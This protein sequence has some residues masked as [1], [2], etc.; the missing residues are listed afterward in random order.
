[1]LTLLEQNSVCRLRG[2]GLSFSH[3]R[4]AGNVLHRLQRSRVDG[5]PKVFL[6]GRTELGPALCCHWIE[7][8]SLWHVV[9]KQ[10]PLQKS[11]VLRY[12]TKLRSILKKIHNCGV[13]H[14]DVTPANIVVGK[15]GGVHLIDFGGAVEMDNVVE[16]GCYSQC[17]G[18]F[19]A[20][21]YGERD[22][23]NDF[24]SLRLCMWFALLGLREYVA[25]REH[26]ILPKLELFEGIQGENLENI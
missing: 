26:G 20:R 14:L 19:R 8:D 7:G 4:N 6:T 24:E 18:L 2:G 1:V 5:I 9:T 17:H 25:H 15:D 22:E 21:V 10:G 11:I 23:R 3:I 12:Y 13:L 16:G